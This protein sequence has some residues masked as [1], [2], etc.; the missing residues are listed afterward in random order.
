MDLIFGSNPGL[1][2]AAILKEKERVEG[3]VK[4]E[5]VKKEAVKKE[6]VNVRVEEVE[7]KIEVVEEAVVDDVDDW[8][9]EHDESAVDDPE[10]DELKSMI[11]SSF[12]DDVFHDGSDEEDGNWTYEQDMN[13]QRYGQPDGK[14][15]GDDCDDP[16]TKIEDVISTYDHWISVKKEEQAQEETKQFVLFCDLDGVL[17]DF[18]AGVQKLF[19][20]KKTSGECC[21]T[22]F[23]FVIR[24]NSMA[25]HG[26]A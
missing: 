18:E 9:F 23:Q 8:T 12:S 17:V 19:K 13:Y 16:G 2:A 14:Q 3:L 1:K 4:K 21:H 5:M 20:K 22:A 11:S 6:V 25:W 24:Q 10:L 7:E 15:E 26:M